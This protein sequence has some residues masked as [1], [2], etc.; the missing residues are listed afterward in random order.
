MSKYEIMIIVNPKVN[1]S[2][3]KDLLESVF[4]KGI[5]KVEKLEKT[6]LAYEIKKSKQA[7][8]L[9]AEVNSNPELISEF[10]RRAN[11]INKEIWR[12]LVINLDTE[13]GFN[14][15]FKNVGKRKFEPHVKKE[16]NEE[17]SEEPKK[18]TFFTNKNKVENKEVKE[19][20]SEQSE[21][22]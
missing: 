3:A 16:K 14:K 7:Q 8:Y 18:R 2:V 19:K 9:L 6:K 11:N 17:N 20:K 5:S 12:Y 4:S 15:E 22:K 10:T 1:I 21:Q 13:K